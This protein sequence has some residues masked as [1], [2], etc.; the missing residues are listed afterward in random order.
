MKWKHS[1]SKVAA[2]EIIFTCSVKQSVEETRSQMALLSIWLQ[3]ADGLHVCAFLEIGTKWENERVSN[4]FLM[5][6]HK[7]TKLCFHRHQEQCNCRGEIVAEAHMCNE[8]ICKFCQMC[9]ALSSL[10]WLKK[11]AYVSYFIASV[12]PHLQADHWLHLKA[13]EHLY[14]S[15]KSNAK[16]LQVF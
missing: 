3:V 1:A 2:L 15:F 8:S 11:S 9:T 16:D 14:V 10:S 4:V 13:A 12:Q 7:N 6:C 5:A